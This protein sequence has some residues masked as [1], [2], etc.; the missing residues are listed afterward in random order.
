MLRQTCSWKVVCVL[1]FSRDFPPTSKL[2][3]TNSQFRV[4]FGGNGTFH[5]RKRGRTFQEKR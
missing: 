4:S 5:D 1:P 2:I 3:A